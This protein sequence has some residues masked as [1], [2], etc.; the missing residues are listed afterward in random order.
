MQRKTKIQNIDKGLITKDD[1]QKIQKVNDTKKVVSVD[2]FKKYG[3]PD[4][5]VKL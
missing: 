2:F 3:S 5:W 4:E 1:L